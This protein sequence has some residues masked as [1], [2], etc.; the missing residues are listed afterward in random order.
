MSALDV[1]P[2]PRL[3]ERLPV[4]VSLLQFQRLYKIFHQGFDETNVITSNGLNF[5]G[6]GRV[7][8]WCW[9]NFQCRGGGGPSNLDYTVE[10]QWL[11]HLWDY[12]NLFE[13]GV[14]RAIEGLL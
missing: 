14:V 9:V 4:N 1:G 13:T 7:E 10:L 12:A 3:A 8:R 11:E 6:D 2:V 5:S